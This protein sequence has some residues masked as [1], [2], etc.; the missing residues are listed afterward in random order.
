VSGVAGPAT[1][2]VGLGSNLGNRA[3]K[4]EEA[5]GEL[6]KLGRLV[7]CSSVYETAPWQVGTQPLYLNQVCE[8]ETQIPPA[9]LM[10]KLLQA[11]RRLGRR[12]LYRGEPR[13]IDIDLLFY[14]DQVV[15]SRAVRVPH[16]RAAERAF[17]LVPLVEIAPGLRHPELG[18]AVEELLEKADASGV[19]KA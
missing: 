9:Q 15:D 14:G 4:L 16:P 3:R 2:Y 13:T 1:A 19:R 17:V 12:R 11:E 5:R 6:A 8:L 18:V 10:R 7:R